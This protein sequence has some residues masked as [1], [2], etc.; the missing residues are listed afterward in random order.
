MYG[1]TIKFPSSFICSSFVEGETKEAFC[2]TN[3]FLYMLYP[4][5]KEKTSKKNTKKCFHINNI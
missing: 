3:I 5:N 4:Q 2:F 1:K